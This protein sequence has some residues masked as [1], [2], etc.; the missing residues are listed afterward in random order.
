MPSGC[1]RGATPQQPPRGHQTVPP[2]QPQN[3]YGI[4]KSCHPIQKELRR[5]RGALHVA[6]L[7]ENGGARAPPGP[8]E[9]T[10]AG[11]GRERERGRAQ[12]D[13]CALASCNKAHAGVLVTCSLLCCQAADM[14]LLAAGPGALSSPPLLPPARPGRAP[15]ASAALAGV[16]G[17]GAPCLLPH[18]PWGWRPFNCS[19]LSPPPF[20]SSPPPPGRSGTAAGQAGGTQPEFRVW[21]ARHVG[22][23]GSSWF[24]GRGASWG[25]YGVWIPSACPESSPEPPAGLIA[26][27]PVTPPAGGAA[28]TSPSPLT[29]RRC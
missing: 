22:R 19:S 17:E 16:F 7:R 26:P 13:A 21:G 8:G 12:S 3:I 28:E 9:L 15:R 18:A 4:T 25:F 27:K 14:P 6:G 11:G 20:R 2:A 23:T 1:H 29:R 10:T 24:V 5:A